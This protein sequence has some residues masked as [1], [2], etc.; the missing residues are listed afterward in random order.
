[1]SL[2]ISAKLRPSVWRSH[3]STEGLRPFRDWLEEDEF[4]LRRKILKKS[5]FSKRY[6]YL[7]MISYR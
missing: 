7:Y 6:F 2:V 3:H 1:M 5:L 4:A